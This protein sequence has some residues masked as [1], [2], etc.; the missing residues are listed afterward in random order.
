MALPDL[1]STALIA[2]LDAC[3]RLIVPSRDGFI[4]TEAANWAAW[5]MMGFEWPSVRL[6]LAAA[7]SATMEG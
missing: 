3:G 7:W 4:S 5:R 1:A 2:Y 6:A